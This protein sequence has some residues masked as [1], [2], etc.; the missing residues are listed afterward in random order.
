[1][2][3]LDFE[4]PVVTTDFHNT[5]QP[6]IDFGRQAGRIGQL[7][8]YLL[9]RD[10]ASAPTLFPFYVLWQLSARVMLGRASAL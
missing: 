10:T 2:V 7:R 8:C 1:M 6:L 9:L 3:D 5:E 4:L